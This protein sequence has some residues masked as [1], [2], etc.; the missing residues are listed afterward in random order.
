[1]YDGTNIKRGETFLDT[2]SLVN[3]IP[4]THKFLES[5]A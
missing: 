2:V 3:Q 1:M 4:N 5:F